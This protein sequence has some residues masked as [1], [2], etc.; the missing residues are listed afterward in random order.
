MR[1][2]NRGLRRPR[3]GV[4]L[5]PDGQ[6]VRRSRGGVEYEPF[7]LSLLLG[8]TRAVCAQECVDYINGLWRHLVGSLGIELGPGVAVL[9][10]KEC[11]AVGRGECE[12]VAYV[13]KS[14]AVVTAAPV[15]QE[16]HGGSSKNGCASAASSSIFASASEISALSGR[17]EIRRMVSLIVFITSC[18]MLR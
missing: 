13:G 18:L 15:A 3:R 2:A 17:A 9:S 1:P 11:A 5:V 14:F 10:R 4:L 12:A 16:H 6:G 7:E 8:G